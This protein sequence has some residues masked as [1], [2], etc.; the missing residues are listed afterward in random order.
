VEAIAYRRIEQEGK[1]LLRKTE[2][3]KKVKGAL[4]AIIT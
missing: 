2:D 3:E 4:L 1:P